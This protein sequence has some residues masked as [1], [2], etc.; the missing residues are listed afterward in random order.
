MIYMIYIYIYGIIYKYSSSM[1]T[2]S[3]LDVK[4][5]NQTIRDAR[6]YSYIYN[7]GV[8]QRADGHNADY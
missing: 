3:P 8:Q 7:I 6:G 4:L 2:I 5:A 1:D